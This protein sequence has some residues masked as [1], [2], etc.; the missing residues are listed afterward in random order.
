MK[1]ITSRIIRFALLIALV[2]AVFGTARADDAPQWLRTAASAT[3]PTYDKDVP[4]VVLYDE[5]Q[6]SLGTDGKL[7]TTENFA[8]RILTRDG[9]SFAIARADYLSNY[10][11]VKDILAWLIRPDGSVKYYDKKTVIDAISDTD[12]IYNES[13]FKAI[14]GA[15]DVNPGFVFGYTTVVE[16]SPLIYQDQWMFQ[17]RLPTLFSRYSLS[18]P[19]GWSASSITF[20]APEI[21]PSVNG[22]TYTWEMRDLAP[23]RPEPMSPKPINLAPR[24]AVNYAPPAGQ[25]GVNRAFSNWAD[26]SRWASSMHDPQVIVDDAIAAKARELTANATTELDKIRAIGTFVQNLQY[27]AIDIGLGYGNGYKPRPSTM[28]LGRGYGDCKDK[29]NLMR[30]LLR[31]VKIDAYPIAI[32]SGDPTFVREQWAS[33]R[34]F[35][36]CIIAIKVSDATVA[37]TVIQNEKLGRLLIFDA[38][39]PYTPVGDLPGYEQGSLALI[40]AGDLGG[41]SRMP[42]TPPGTD[43]LERSVNVDLSGLG[44]IKGTI[45]EHA[46]GQA[47][48]MF[49]T[50]MRALSATDYRK[51][52]EG[53]LTRGATGAQLVTVKPNDRF[54]ESRFDLDVDFAA[55]LYAQ[56]M[57]DRLL[58]FKPA[59]VGRRQDI[60]LTE[61]KRTTPVELDGF[62]LRETATF[63][64]PAGFAVDET[65]DPVTL[66][67]DFGRYTT[68]YE[69]Q[70]GKLLFTRTMSMKRMVVPVERYDA[71]KAFFSKVRDADQSPIV[72]ARK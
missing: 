4:A 46:N 51:A 2:A 63:T 16:D 50:E 58:V 17:E 47:S 5:D 14:Y 29:A 7:S 33:P 34:Q 56:L 12:D 9:R 42:V 61:A 13:R 10:S 53:W 39:D 55:P 6:V 62:A 35:N 26:V 15:D 43:L 44:G 65:P 68:K 36:H 24:I 45:S 25:N 11:K 31:A 20:N 37:P 67:T 40:A 23:I 1:K 32:F 72:L 52:L 48:T 70:G 30:S 19:A 49:R 54:A 21:K 28:V 64:L 60:Y 22:S 59:I 18:L 41:L 69:V 57:Q 27:I 8:V 71:L 38:T 3:V 66:D